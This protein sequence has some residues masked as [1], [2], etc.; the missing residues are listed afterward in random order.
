MTTIYFLGLDIIHT[1]CHITTTHGVPRLTAF[2]NVRSPAEVVAIRGCPSAEVDGRAADAWSLGITI[3]A[4]MTG[5]IPFADATP[6]NASYAEFCQRME[7]ETL[8]A[9]FH[10]GYMRGGVSPHLVCLAWARLLLS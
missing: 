4:L 6:S 9:V 2:H 8:G 7:G 3:Y 1:T 5:M 10:K